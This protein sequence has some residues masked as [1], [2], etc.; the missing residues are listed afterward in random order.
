MSS[1]FE[2]EVWPAELAEIEKRRRQ[3]GIDTGHLDGAPSVK[4]GITGLA[5][6]GGG[7][8]SASF[9]LG[10]IQGLIRKGVF[11]SIDYLSTVSG[12]GYIG[13]CL[14]SALGKRIAPMASARMTRR[15]C[16]SN[17]EPELLKRVDAGQ[18]L[19]PA[20]TETDLDHP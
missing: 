10:V 8:R 6:S 12:G 9:S 1:Q 5:L 7:I 2:D 17:S 11:G 19:W 18:D 3:R 14:S 16:R 13:S 4:L 20:V 15:G